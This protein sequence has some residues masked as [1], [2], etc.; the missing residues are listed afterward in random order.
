M[1]SS[2]LNYKKSFLIT[3]IFFF[4]QGVIFATWASR[5][6]DIKSTLE[7]SDA[8]LGGVIFA[9][10]V[11]QLSLISLFAWAVNRFSSLRSL[12]FTSIALPLSLVGVG[13]TGSGLMGS[14]IMP[15]I[16]ALFFFGAFTNFNNLCINTQAINV[17]RLYSKSVMP[18]FHG[19]WSLG[20]FSGALL[21]FALT[22]VGASIV[23]HF[24]IVAILCCLFALYFSRSLISE[25]IKGESCSTGKGGGIFKSI[26]SS[27][28]LLGV[29]S[30][31]AMMCEGTMF[32]WSNIYFQDIVGAPSSLVP[33]G[34][35]VCMCTMT[36]GRFLAGIFISRYGS[37]AVVR[38]SGILIAVGLT[39]AVAFPN[40]ISTTI[41][42][43]IVGFGISSNVPVC[44]SLAGRLSNVAP[45]I[46]IAA[47]S[48]IGCFG[49]LIGPP[50]I[51]VI[52]QAIGL[53]FTFGLIIILALSI[54]Y[55]VGYL[56]DSQKQRS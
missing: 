9:I 48:T 18:T 36:I 34:Y 23:S 7:L 1:T 24:S 13:I 27:I 5:I 52:T 6:I 30:F 4:I 46:A 55:L 54:V 17:E 12:C 22:S 47:V 31:A 53:R 39:L 11:G 3:S 40:I 29:I 10:P 33:L 20:A 43:M 26:N 2:I 8:V 15:L 19:M 44:Y 41:G 45:S 25:D 37:I 50:I 56:K 32:D 21:S 28:I 51:G 38:T 16:V 42:F 14:G 35:I 49:F